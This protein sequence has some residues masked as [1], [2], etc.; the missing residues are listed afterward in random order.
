MDFFRLSKALAVFTDPLNLLAFVLLAALV[1]LWRGRWTGARR[2]L[3]F[4]VAA[5]FAVTLFPIGDLLLFG[6]EQ[7]FPAP[8]SPPDKVDGIIMLGG[9]AAVVW[10]N[11]ERWQKP[12]FLAGVAAVMASRWW[13]LVQTLRGESM[14]SLLTLQS[15][16]FPWETWLVLPLSWFLLLR[17]MG[18]TIPSAEAQTRKTTNAQVR[19]PTMKAEQRVVVGRNTRW[20][21][22]FA[23]LPA[24][25]NIRQAATPAISPR[26]TLKPKIR[27]SMT[28]VTQALW[29]KVDSQPRGVEPPS[30]ATYSIAGIGLARSRFIAMSR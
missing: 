27:P 21:A 28:A 15:A 26:S 24:S 30:L 13:A 11:L 18:H 14:A 23:R 16:T 7:R 22:I 1:L 29:S 2:L 9:V 5:L 4:A 6:L 19:Q 20:A 12:V 8:A 10:P 17:D 25:L 3:A